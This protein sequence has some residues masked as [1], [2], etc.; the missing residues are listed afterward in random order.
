M[1]WFRTSWW[2]LCIVLSVKGLRQKFG[3]VF[4]IG[5]RGFDLQSRLSG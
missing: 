1:D 3:F 4:A 5:Y 2:S